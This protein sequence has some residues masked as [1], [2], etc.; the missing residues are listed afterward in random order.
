MQTVVNITLD[1]S[2]KR[3]FIPNAVAVGSGGSLQ[4]T[5]QVNG[6][7]ASLT[8]I[9]MGTSN[10][11]DSVIDTYT[12]TSNTTR[13]ISL[14]QTFDSFAAVGTWTGGSDVTVGVTATATGAGQ[15]FSG[16]APGQIMVGTTSPVGAVAAPVGTLF[17][18]SAGLVG[19][20]LF[21]KTSGGSTS[22]GWSAIA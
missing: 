21:V 20:V 13:T 18:N 17:V 16:G 7:P 1:Q 6:A 15:T 4:V 14:P 19:S 9:V 12:G 5:Y 11:I 2:G 8:I 3:V 10:G 22:A